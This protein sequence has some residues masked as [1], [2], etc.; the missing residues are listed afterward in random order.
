[1]FRFVAQDSRSRKGAE[2]TLVLT[3]VGVLA[4]AYGDQLLILAAA[5]FFV[6][7]PF[8]LVAAAEAS[9]GP[10][11]VTVTT[12]GLWVDTFRLG[13]PSQMVTY[14]EGQTLMLANASA[15]DRPL[16]WL[17]GESPEQRNNLEALVALLQATHRPRTRRSVYRS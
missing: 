13:F 5:L 15:E 9:D 8:G 2:F 17:K 16:A 11:T 14:W 3:L 6:V 10:H 4:T 12:N 7:P 1:V